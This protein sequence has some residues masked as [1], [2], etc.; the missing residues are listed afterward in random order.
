MKTRKQ[1]RRKEGRLRRRRTARCSVGVRY[2]RRKSETLGL[3]SPLPLTSSVCVDL[4]SSKARIARPSTRLTGTWFEP[5][6][7]L[8][9]VKS[10]CSVVPPGLERLT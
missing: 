7:D 2:Q 10:R 1:R 5:S 4:L 6:A 3:L 9:V 8:G